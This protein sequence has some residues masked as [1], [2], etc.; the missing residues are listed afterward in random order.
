M[1][2]I[3]F[4]GTYLQLVDKSWRSN[5]QHSDYRHQDC[6]INNKLLKRLHL[7]CWHHTHTHD[8]YAMQ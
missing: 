1:E 5:T 8:N 6:I 7:K 3:V 2:Q 4:K